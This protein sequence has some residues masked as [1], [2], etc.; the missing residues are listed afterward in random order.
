MN[1]L[2]AVVLPVIAALTLSIPNIVLAGPPT[3]AGY[4]PNEWYSDSGMIGYYSHSNT[5]P[6]T[7]LKVFYGCTAGCTMGTTTLTTI[8][9]AGFDSWASTLPVTRSSG[10]QS[11]CHIMNVG[12]TRNEAYQNNLP[13]NCYG[14]GYLSSFTVPYYGTTSTG[15]NKS[16]ALATQSVVMYVWDN[17][18]KN[19]STDKWKAIASHEMGHA[20]GYNGHDN[21][22]GGYPGYT[23]ISIMNPYLDL[24]WDIWGIKAPQTRDKNH[25]KNTYSKF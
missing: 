14:L 6:Y 25:I 13:D 24:Y 20:L 11:N 8:A 5:S 9:S 22:T 18:S 15:V 16:I 7:S 10:T 19:F 1:K 17:T 21:S 2:K 4:F 3:N 23:P 12:I